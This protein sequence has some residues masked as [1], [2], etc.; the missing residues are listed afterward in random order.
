MTRQHRPQGHPRRR[1]QPHQFIRRRRSHHTAAGVAAAWAEVQH[2]VGFG[3]QVQVVL[4]DHHTVAGIN[5]PVQHMD[6]FSTS[7][8]CRPT[9]GSSS[10]ESG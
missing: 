6:E 10:T 4:D 9:V 7:A 3:D 1:L 8:M 2:L 5:E